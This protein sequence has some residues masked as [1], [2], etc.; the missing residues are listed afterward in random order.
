MNRLKPLVAAV[1]TAA[2]LG[3]AAVATPS[4]SALT[5]LPPQ[6]R[7]DCTRQEETVGMYLRVLQALRILGC[8]GTQAY[9]EV[10]AK[11]EAAKIRY[12]SCMEPD[13]PRF[14]G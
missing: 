6:P 7:G 12:G 3:T 11:L 2:V 14:G 4:A 5:R 8:G 1:L 13:E 9:N 10:L